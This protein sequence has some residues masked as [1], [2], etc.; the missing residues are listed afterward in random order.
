MDQTSKFRQEH[1]IV[2]ITMPESGSAGS[3]HSYSYMSIIVPVDSGKMT[4]E[5]HEKLLGFLMKLSPVIVNI[6]RQEN[7]KE[8]SQGGTEMYTKIK[9]PDDLWEIAKRDKSFLYRCLLALIMTENESVES[10]IKSCQSIPSTHQA[11]ST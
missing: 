9:T 10:R 6:V 4:G 1:M 11:S 8:L 3:E 7:I 5:D 2:S